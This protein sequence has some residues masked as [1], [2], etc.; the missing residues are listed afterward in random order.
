[1]PVREECVV[2]KVDELRSQRDAEVLSMQDVPLAVHR[3]LVLNRGTASD[4]IEYEV[5]RAFA[6]GLRRGNLMH[7]VQ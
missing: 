6:V 5:Q 2:S 1:M 4:D 3:P 7:Q